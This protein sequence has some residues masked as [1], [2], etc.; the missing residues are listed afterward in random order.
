MLS[1]SAVSGVG[2]A[3]TQATRLERCP[4]PLTQASRRFP[5]HAAPQADRPL[6]D[7]RAAV[8]LLLMARAAGD[9]GALAA[10]GGAAFFT[11][12]LGEADARVRHYASVF[13]LRELQLQ[14]P[15]QY[16][17]GAGP[18]RGCRAAVL[19]CCCAA[20]LLCCCVVCVDLACLAAAAAGH[21][22][23]LHPCR[24]SLGPSTDAL[25]PYPNP[26]QPA[27]QSPALSTRRRA[28][29]GVVARAQAANDERLLSNPHLQLR[30]MLEIGRVQLEAL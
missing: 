29:R 14:H 5:C 20:V 10:L 8:L 12:L 3:V 21:L 2:I 1:G 25:V 19:L 7:A 23:D 4:K 6:W 27:H 9:G 18:R 22:L 13:V 16:R 24:S 15:L 17:C 26:T 11:G 28:L 30:A